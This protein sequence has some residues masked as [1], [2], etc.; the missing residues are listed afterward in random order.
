MKIIALL[1]AVLLSIPYF[2]FWVWTVQYITKTSPTIVHDIGFLWFIGL[3][4][5]ACQYLCLLSWRVTAWYDVSMPVTVAAHA[6]AA[7]IGIILG[8]WWFL[9]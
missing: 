3:G 6:L 5:F 1:I 4:L 8:A 7:V 9:A 2:V